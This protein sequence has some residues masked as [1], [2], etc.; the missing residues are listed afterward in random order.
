MRRRIDEATGHAARF[1][2]VAVFV[3]VVLLMWCGEARAQAFQDFDT[4]YYG[5]GG[6]PDQR[7]NI[8]R[9]TLLEDYLPVDDS[10]F[11]VNTLTDCTS[12]AR[13]TI[14]D[15][16]DAAADNTK[17]VLPNCSM[18]MDDD[19]GGR[20]ETFFTVPDTADNLVIE[21]QASTKFYITSSNPDRP[22]S[23]A[24][25]RHVLFAAGVEGSTPAAVA[26]W[27]WDVD[28]GGT[29]VCAAQGSNVLCASTAIG[30]TAATEVY[31][32]DIVQIRADK[33]QGG[34]GGDLR[35]MY[36]VVCAVWNDGTVHPTDH[37]SC[38]SLANNSIVIDEVLQ[39][40]WTG[41]PYIQNAVGAYGNPTI[42]LLERRGDGTPA[43]N[44][45]QMI[46]GLVLRGFEFEH[47]NPGMQDGQYAP[48]EIHNCFECVI[49]DTT[50]TNG[51]G[52]TYF[53]AS[54]A[55]G[56]L[57]VNQNDWRGELYR[58]E[59]VI[60]VT[61]VTTGTP[62]HVVGTKSGCT[63]SFACAVNTNPGI[64]GNNIDP[65]IYFP[66]D[67]DVVDL[68]GT[69]KACSC[70]AAESADCSNASFDVPLYDIGTGS[71][72]VGT[73]FTETV[74]GPSGNWA[75]QLNAYN[76]ATGYITKEVSE[77]QFIDNYVEDPRVGVICEKGGYGTT[78]AY[79]K[80]VSNDD[81][82]GPLRGALFVHGAP[83]SY[84]LV[85]GND[86]DVGL[87]TRA[88]APQGIG[89]GPIFTLFRNRVE[90]STTRTAISS[91]GCADL[92]ICNEGGD[93]E[94]NASENG[95]WALNTLPDGGSGS[96]LIADC[97]NNP[98]SSGCGSP[99][100]EYEFRIDANLWYD[101]NVDTVIEG[102]GD[103]TGNNPTFYAPDVLGFTQPMTSLH[104]T[105]AARD[106]P[107]SIYRDA[108][109]T[110]P[111]WWC[112][113]SGTFPNIGAE[114]DVW[115]GTTFTSKSRLP[116]EIR[117]AGDTCTLAGAPAP[118][119][120]T[121]VGGAFGGGMSTN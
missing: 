101:Q 94:G 79:N 9:V 25:W 85:E 20:A 105:I 36:E 8:P 12:T 24:E 6:G 60:T 23:G 102:N 46:E 58:T 95:W 98:G 77:V 39:I 21:G 72:T 112:D 35:H 37:A 11:T 90:N 80:F 55:V 64:I 106:L 110:A 19:D 5:T 116:A 99:Y 71:A 84:S 43:D 70:E 114:F 3:W 57:L 28:R 63:E 73:T 59:C 76:V 96:P 52:P 67:F 88:T 75:S 113:E 89:V 78:I 65:Y 103:G 15:A 13:A 74:S 34:S 56:R 104:A 93:Q 1:M 68:R 4:S 108:A 119:P 66:M 32:T 27:A 10:G 62:A 26:S 31:G 97:E 69:V 83:C 61:D 100:F 44:T 45:D 54:N 42:Y 41:A 120:A 18:T 81:N 38:S 22:A 109:G 14:Q 92:G 30:A 49:T 121:I 91:G 50:A 47:E 2:F 33:I 87:V 7:L 29:G 40:D 107:T 115:N 17:I 48:F 118:S 86:G 117:A 53:H 82:P 51:F 16:I 111:D